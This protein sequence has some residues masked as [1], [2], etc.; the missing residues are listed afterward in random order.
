M[1]KETIKTVI[2][3]ADISSVLILA[4]IVMKTYLND[5]TCFKIFDMFLTVIPL[6][7]IRIGEMLLERYK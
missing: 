7:I 6:L 1:K 3:V 2:I 4:Y 5:Y